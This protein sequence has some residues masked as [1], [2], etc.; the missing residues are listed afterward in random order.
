[1]RCYRSLRE[2]LEIRPSLKVALDQRS[3]VNQLAIRRWQYLRSY[4]SHRIPT[5]TMSTHYRELKCSGCNKPVK[6]EG[7]LSQHEASCKDVLARSQNNRERL[8]GLNFKSLMA[9]RFAK[10]PRLEKNTDTSESS[11]IPQA[12]SSQLRSSSSAL[13]K[14]PAVSALSNQV[15]DLSQVFQIVKWGCLL[16]Y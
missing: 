4:L 6:S 7:G 2:S 16:K 13:A 15:S 14:E 11:P 8:R 3:C 9:G 12:G 10:K 1:M 5:Q